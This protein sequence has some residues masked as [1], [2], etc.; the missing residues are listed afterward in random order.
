MAYMSDVSVPKSP[1]CG[2]T[3]WE[4]EIDSYTFEIEQGKEDVEVTGRGSDHGCKRIICK[5]CGA[6][7]DRDT[8]DEEGKKQFEQLEDECL[9]LL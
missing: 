3:R 6:Q 7:F 4:V 2:A 9:K 1:H 8:Q 5:D